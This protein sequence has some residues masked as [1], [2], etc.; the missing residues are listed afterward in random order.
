MCGF[1][2]LSECELR[3]GQTQR[4]AMVPKSHRGSRDTFPTE[5]VSAPEEVSL[6][7]VS[8]TAFPHGGRE[9]VIQKP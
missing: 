4:G 2:S 8:E 6:E 7:L 5:H 1:R 3:H 9:E